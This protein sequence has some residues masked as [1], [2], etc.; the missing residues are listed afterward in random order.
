MAGERFVVFGDS[1]VHIDERTGDVA[2]CGERVVGWELLR[3]LIGSRILRYGRLLQLGHEVWAAL[4]EFNE[5]FFRRG[6]E[7]AE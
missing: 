7:H 4:H 1:V 3:L 5:A 6:K 2:V